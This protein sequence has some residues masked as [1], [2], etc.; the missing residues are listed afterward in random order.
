MASSDFPGTSA[1]RVT[2]DD[3]RRLCEFLYRRT[4]MSFDD[5]K[6]SSSTVNSS[7]E[8]SPRNRIRSNRISPCSVQ[9]PSMRSS[10]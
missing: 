7:S 10:I 9:M 6:R 2:L 3:V 8:L 1:I 5:N 4:G